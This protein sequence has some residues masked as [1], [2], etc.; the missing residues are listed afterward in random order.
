M[1]RPDC[2]GRDIALFPFRF[3]K[4]RSMDFRPVGG[5]SQGAQRTDAAF[6]AAAPASA[7]RHSA[8]PVQTADAVEQP[9]RRPAPGQVDDAVKN[10]NQAMK[11]LSPNLEFSIDTDLDRTIVKVVDQQT[12]DVIRQIPSQEAVEISKALDRLQGL[13]IRQKA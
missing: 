9:A 7:A 2:S 4:E 12:G 8:A 11:S 6:V 1:S 3:L 10:I 5:N 13:L